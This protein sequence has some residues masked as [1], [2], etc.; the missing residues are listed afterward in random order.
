MSG[1]Y[2][3]PDFDLDSKLNRLGGRGF[4]RPNRGY[5][6]VK[7][8]IQDSDVNQ[9]GILGDCWFLS[10]LSS[11]AVY[12]LSLIQRVLNIEYNSRNG[13]TRGKLKF[14]FY[15]FDRWEQVT[16]DDRVPK[17]QDD[18]SHVTGDWWPILVEKAYAK[19]NG[20]YDAIDGGF[21]RISMHHLTGGISIDLATD[22]FRMDSR[23]VRF[24]FK[25]FSELH[26]T[27][28]VFINCGNKGDSYGRD[29]SESG[30]V[31]IMLILFW[32]SQK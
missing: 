32:M 18:M 17:V 3:D 19:F 21:P 26:Q 1:L 16:I 29:R 28:R 30:I 6:F 23:D 14:F 15:R 7:N 5:S 4:F 10:A 22:K 11:L 8:G 12:D 25:L 24:W 27:K 20:S 2:E 9:K 13:P 31:P